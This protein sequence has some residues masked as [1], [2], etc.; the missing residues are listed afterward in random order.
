[1]IAFSS[2]LEMLKLTRNW[3]PAG[4]GS[5]KRRDS[6]LALA[7]WNRPR[8]TILTTAL[9]VDAAAQMALT[10]RMDSLAFNLANANTTGF[11]SEG[12]K[13]DSVLSTTGGANVAF[14][15]AGADYISLA[16]GAMRKTG[17][18]LDVAVRGDGWLSVL[19]PAGPAY[20]RDGR[21]QI[22]AG[23]SVRSI[24]GYPV[25]DAGGAPL[26]IDASAGEVSIAAD[27]AIS[28]RGKTVGI[29]GLFSLE[30]DARLSRHDNSSVLSDREATPVTPSS[31]AGLMQG[32]LEQSNVN[33][34]LE[35]T[36]MIE[37][38]RTFDHIS[39]C[40]NMTDNA[41]QDAIRT[42]GAQT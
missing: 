13:F 25:L 32:F 3:T 9:Y 7:T 41:Q 2:R 4:Q 31:R 27:G 19:T 24:A 29:L 22:D 28:Q 21:L 42:L 16:H 33:P 23:G 17:N 8:R 18:A 30:P 40:L 5:R 14:P 26:A 11:L 39:A 1:M 15:N 10:R 12:L 35:L 20:T 34:L 37:I 6:C 36:K 38:Q